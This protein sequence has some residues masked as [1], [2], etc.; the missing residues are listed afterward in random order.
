MPGQ[1]LSQ[2]GC[3]V[4]GK[5]HGGRQTQLAAGSLARCSQL[6]PRLVGGGAQGRALRVDALARLR[7]RQLARGAVQQ[8]HPAF[9]LQQAHLLA[10]GGR[11]HAQCPPRATHGAV[12]HHAGKHRHAPEIVHFCFPLEVVWVGIL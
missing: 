10:D 4:P 8:R 9:A 5:T 7:Q 6:G 2:R 3:H 1:Q 12:L 11:A